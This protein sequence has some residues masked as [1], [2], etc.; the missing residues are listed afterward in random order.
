MKDPVPEQ[1]QTAIK[2]IVGT[3]DQPGPLIQ[4]VEILRCHHVVDDAGSRDD[5]LADELRALIFAYPTEAVGA[6]TAAL[7]ALHQSGDGLGKGLEILAYHIQAQ[8]GGSPETVARLLASGELSDMAVVDG[9]VLRDVDEGDFLGD[10]EEDDGD[11]DST[12]AGTDPH[13]WT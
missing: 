9:R 2:E 5:E 11:A 8:F 12:G 1:V 6:C 4:I 13:E 10:G 3:P 7:S